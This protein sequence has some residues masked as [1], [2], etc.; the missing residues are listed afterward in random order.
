MSFLGIGPWIPRAR[1]GE[2][3]SDEDSR[4]T[5]EQIFVKLTYSLQGKAGQAVVS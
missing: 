3:G 1:L 4:L 5:C 2:L